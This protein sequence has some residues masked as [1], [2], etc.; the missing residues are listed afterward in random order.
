MESQKEPLA[1]N[2]QTTKTLLCIPSLSII[3]YHHFQKE[4]ESKQC[5]EIGKVMNIFLMQFTRVK[6]KVLSFMSQ[7]I[8]QIVMFGT[9]AHTHAEEKERIDRGISA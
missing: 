7:L 2:Y 1:Q 8:M 4:L 3:I 9:C 6:K 5:D